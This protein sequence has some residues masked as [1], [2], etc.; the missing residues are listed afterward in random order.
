MFKEGGIMGTKCMQA[1]Q[2]SVFHKKDAQNY[3]LVNFFLFCQTNYLITEVDLD[4]LGVSKL[5]STP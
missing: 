2:F 3:V 5:C 4:L 1:E